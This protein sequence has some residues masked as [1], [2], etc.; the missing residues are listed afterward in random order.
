MN[1]NS[2]ISKENDSSSASF[3]SFTGGGPSSGTT[4][5]GG[6]S[7][8]STPN[9]GHSSSSRDYRGDRGMTSGDMH[10]TSELESTGSYQSAESLI[11]I[12]DTVCKL[13]LYVFFIPP[14]IFSWWSNRDQTFF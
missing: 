7:P 2:P 6:P 5:D 13:I 4:S 11:G 1:N 12:I 10:F 3:H 14:K 8:N 9:R